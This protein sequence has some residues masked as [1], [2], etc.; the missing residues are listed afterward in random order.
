MAPAEH[1]LQL[2]LPFG[3]PV[4][5][6]RPVA[7]RL[8]VTDELPGTIA[9][10]DEVPAPAGYAVFDCET[11]GTDPAA[12]EI[13]SLALV[14]LDADGVETARFTTLVRP[15]RAIPAAA[16]AVHGIAD[17]D[18]A[19]A[20]RLDQV[21]GELLALLDDAVFVAHHV[22]F[23]LPMLRHGLE[24]VGIDYTPAATACTLESFR[25]L[26]PRADNHRLE[27][28]CAVHGIELDGAHEALGDVLATAALLRLIL[29]AG[30][31]PESVRLDRVAY[32]RVR[33]RGDVRPATEPQ[34]RRVFGL[35]R[36]AGLVEDDGSVD[37][38]QVLEVVR[39][40]A[41]ADDPDAL[42]REQVQDVFEVL[43]AMV[44]A[45]TAAPAPGRPAVAG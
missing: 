35:A 15:G 42:T 6:A 23:D 2:E 43:E 39:R 31:A 26:E 21:A 40:V 19:D 36:A 24:R 38:A 5:P 33:S 27:S 28:L 8:E 10:R 30:L 37:R 7:P 44:A 45:R 34:V 14:R 32:Q 17:E 11:T 22:A 9:R 12:D 41:G 13:V 4:P 16:T 18:V 20:P 3:E 29:G 1:A 25:L